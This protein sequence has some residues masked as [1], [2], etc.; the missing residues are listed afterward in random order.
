MK[1]ALFAALTLTG[2]LAMVLGLASNSAGQV[3]TGTILGT[4]TDNSGAV[5]P[6]A[7]V[8]ITEIN[9]GT[10]QKYKAD[11]KGDFYVPFLIP[12]TYQGTVEKSGFN[13]EVRSNIVLQVD[14]K[15]RL[16]FRLQVGQVSQTVNVTAEAPLVRSESA[17]LGDVIEEHAVRELPLN[18]RNFAQLVYLSSGVTPGQAGENLSGASTFNPRAASDFNALGSQANTNAWLIDGIDNNEYTFNTVILQPSIESVREFKVLTGTFS[19]E[20]GRGSGVVSVSTKSGSNTLHGSVFEFLRNDLLDAHPYIFV[21][22]EQPKPPFRRNQFGAAVGG[23]IE[24]P[25]IY[26]GHNRTFFFAD[27]FGLRE[28]KGQT[29]VNTVPTAL[30]RTGDFS[31]Y[32]DP[33]TGN[34][35][36]IYDPLTTSPDPSNPGKFLRTAFANNIILA[37][38][39]N[40]VGLNVASIYPLPNGPGNFNNFSSTANR[41]VTDDGFTTRI[42]HRIGDTDNFFGRYQ[43]ERYKLDAPQGQSACCL[44]TPSFAASKFDLGPFVAGIQNTRLRT[45]GLALNE[46]HIFKATLLNEFRT[47]FARTTP[48]TR[49]SDFGHKSATSLGIMG[50][51][52]TEFATGLPNINVQDF[53]GLSGGPAFLPVNP[54]QT[55]YQFEDIVSWSLGHHQTK[56]GYRYIRKLAS[57]FTNTNTRGSLNFNDNFTNNPQTNK[58]GAGIATLLLGFSTGGSR[59]FLLEPYYM[60]NQE[61]AWFFQD[62]WRVKNRLTLNLGLRYDIFSP[63]VEIRNRLVNFDRA[64][65]RLIYA[66]ENGASRTANKSTAHDNFGPRFGFAWAVTEDKKTVVRGG[67]GLS[68]F[69]EM[70]SATPMLGQN[71]PFTISQN[72]SPETNP[73]GTDFLA[74]KIPSINNPFPPIMTV[75][76]LTTADL[77]AANPSV[78][79][80]AFNNLTP[81]AESYSVNVEHQVSPSLLAEVGYAGSRGIHLTFCYN[82]NEVQPGNGSQASR[83]LLQPLANETGINQCDPRNMSNYNSLV[84]KLTK[85]FSNG[86]QF[87]TSYT[88]G[89]SLDYGGSAASGG[90]AVGNPQTITNLRAGYGP[91]GFDVRHRFVFSY[92]YELPF[93]KG[94]RWVS[95]GIASRLVGGWELSGITTLSGGRPFTVFLAQGVNNGAPSWPD[96]IGPGTLSDPTPSLWFNTADFFAPPANTFGN[97]QRGV[98][99]GPGQANFD[100]SF[101]KNTAITERLKIQFRLDAF[102]LFNTPYF[103]FPD[104][105]IGSPTAGKITSTLADMRDLQFALKFEF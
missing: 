31:Q 17:E 6:D 86:L 99:Y 1:R 30:V 15:A 37:N 81:Y 51:N 20:F 97:S 27:Y 93:G 69:F 61:H 38:R 79:A 39:I 95:E 48:T 24:L 102:N 103:G 42:D 26:N 66:G 4:V 60:T 63:D 28:V 8:V 75:K 3:T 49:Q 62:D 50:I 72:Y 94:K 12:G 57:P 64:N 40:Q 56:F 13:K 67:Y 53:T 92:L 65:L 87:L 21:R 96:R 16:D 45:Q 74:G 7:E 70:P 5:L 33:K 83:R 89:R 82:P 29:F 100:A 68:Y 80:H 22:P 47:G 90:G 14:Q 73:L 55:H 44:P 10:S 54:R 18:G 105:N 43:F 104:S 34:L 25:K 36:K 88:W 91:S 11:E 58:E 78:Q 9:K 35:I 52:V 2:C 101:V 98:L 77:N 71:V 41:R 59:G 76:P 23:P 19:S 32:T 85:R 46:T 84:A